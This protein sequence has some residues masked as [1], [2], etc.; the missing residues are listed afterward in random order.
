M[1]VISSFWRK[2][3]HT[4]NAKDYDMRNTQVLHLLQHAIISVRCPSFCSIHNISSS[5]V[6][7]PRI[8][9]Q[10]ESPSA[11]AKTIKRTASSRSHHEIDPWS[12]LAFVTRV[13]TCSARPDWPQ[14]MVLRPVAD[15]QTACPRSRALQHAAS[16]HVRLSPKVLAL[17]T[18]G[19]G[20]GQCR[21]TIQ[22]S[23]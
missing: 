18:Y 15:V 16:F 3:K 22:A 19:P 13:R 10:E 20:R 8:A 6:G 23:P 21:A 2:R 5:V 9:I 4:I 11:E 7:F 17:G 12:S 1:F 14:R